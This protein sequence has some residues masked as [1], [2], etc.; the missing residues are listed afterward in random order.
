[1]RIKYPNKTFGHG[2]LLAE[3]L[4]T[5]QIGYTLT[6]CMSAVNTSSQPKSFADWAAST[7]FWTKSL[8]GLTP[9][10]TGL[11]E[12]LSEYADTMEAA[13]QRTFC[14]VREAAEC[15][16][17]E[18]TQTGGEVAVHQAFTNLDDLA[19]HLRLYFEFKDAPKASSDFITNRHT[20][21][22]KYILMGVI[23]PITNNK[24]SGEPQQL[25]LDSLL[26]Y[27]VILSGEPRG[28][29]QCVGRVFLS[30]EKTPVKMGTVNILNA[31]PGDS[32]MLAVLVTHLT[33]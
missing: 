26:A 17:L 10:Y 1:M 14:A 8:A 33:K 32:D 27:D 24:D 21:V 25:T 18:V 16:R 22:M 6:D 19:A 20:R 2:C 4:R 9:E 29:G 30:A 12:H 7:A 28:G 31:P 11:F 23:E 3:N 13:L 5:E 15:I